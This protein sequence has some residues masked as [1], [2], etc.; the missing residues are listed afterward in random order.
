M[1][2]EEKLGT[3]VNQ[4]RTDEAIATGARTIA[5]GCPF[6]QVMLSDGVASA[7]A[8]VER[9]DQVQVM[10]VARLLLRA[11]KKGAASK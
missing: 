10:D 7:Q 8:D 9:E 3:R 11:A 5:I 6:C 1:W 4:E 2:M